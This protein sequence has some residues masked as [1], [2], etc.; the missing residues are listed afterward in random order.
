MPNHLVDETS[1][2]LLQHKDNPV[3]WYPWG[4]EAFE[5]AKAEDKPV[6]LSVGYSACHWCHVMEHE[7][8]EDEATAAILNEHYVSI[9][10]DREER[11]DVDSVYMNAVQALT[12]RGGWPMSVWLLPDGRPFYGGTYF[13]KEPRYGLPSFKQVLIR[14]AQLY[15]ERR[16]SIEGDATRLTQAIG[17][18]ILLESEHN[19]TPSLKVLESVFQSLAERYD[20]RWGGFG[21]QPK[22]PP[23]MTLELLLRL[24]RRHGWAHA[25]QMV[26][27][28]LDR[29]AW[30]GLYDQI[31]GG[32]HRYSVD[33]KWLV[34]HFEKMLY[35][36]ALLARIY[37]YAYQVTGESRYRRIVEETLAYVKREMTDPAGGFYSTQDADS[38]GEE[39][40]FFIWTQDELCAA[41]A[42]AVQT[43]VVLDY[44]GVTQGPNFEGRSI[45]WVPEPPDQVAAR[46]AMSVDDLMSQVAKAREVLFGVR[47]RR[48]RPGLD[49]KVLTAWNGLMIHTLAQVGRTLGCVD[50]IQMATLAAD[51]ILSALRKEGRLLRTYKNGR[52]HIPAYLEDY[53]ALAEAL[54]ELYQTT[55]DRR[56][57]EEALA[58]TEQ[59]VT[60]FWDD[61]AGFY[62][63]A[64][65]HESLITRPQEVTDNATPAGTSMA[66]AVLARMAILADRPEWHTLV[67]RVLQRLA[68]PLQQ[69]PQAFPYLACQLDFA[70]GEPHEI[71]LVGDPKS[72]DLQ[73]LLEVIHKS[74]RPGQVVALLR[75][76]DRETANSIPLLANRE[77]VGN[78][79]TA[80]VCRKFVCQLPVTTPE[81]LSAQLDGLQAP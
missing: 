11:P 54:I 60:L 43:E 48:I 4:E 21:T 79:A 68:L 53:A 34:P 25:L 35:D 76:G 8:F 59:M 28:T 9:K 66:V 51:F 58:L 38:E 69:Y 57:F 32:F 30:G 5:R 49:D 2:Y 20:P 15:H 81:A 10:V 31:G 72:D 65:D 80:Y 26:T 77:M 19:Q 78:A 16:D 63:T 37:L 52:A 39:G 42:G 71:A 64:T 56:W 1:P 14:I 27:H 18:R 55:F 74:Y 12:G 45:L 62:D 17:G 24:H 44:W 29:M 13:P 46:H 47:E 6:F 61:Q 40:K 36:N 22:F 50:Y 33:E 41:L 3:D 7:S 73:A 70:Y 67:E 23:A 75:H